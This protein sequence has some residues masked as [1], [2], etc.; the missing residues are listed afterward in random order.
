M[1]TAIEYGL[2]AALISVAGIT[3]LTTVGGRRE[4]VPVVEPV[5]G[6][7]KVTAVH[8]RPEVK[9]TPTC[10]TLSPKVPDGRLTVWNIVDL[11][12]SYGRLIGVV[13]DPHSFNCP[14]EATHVIF[15]IER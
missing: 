10:V 11:G 8:G 1:A 14:K 4:Y 3:A 15:T 7:Y 9:V 6:Q 5:K 2:I 12:A 13:S